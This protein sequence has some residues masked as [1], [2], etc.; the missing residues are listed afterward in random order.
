VSS[1]LPRSAPFTREDGLTALTDGDL[2]RPDG[3][4]G[5]KNSLGRDRS[6]LP[7]GGLH[8]FM[9]RGPVRIIIGTSR[10]VDRFR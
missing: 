1:R 9:S 3:F 6:G 4:A 8:L 5:A 7:R 2:G 10:S